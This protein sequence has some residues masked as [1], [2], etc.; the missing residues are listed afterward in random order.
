MKARAVIAMLFLSCLFLILAACGGDSS[1]TSTPA[2]TPTPAGSP[3]TAP[4]GSET[5]TPTPQGLEHFRIQQWRVI[6]DNGTPTLSTSATASDNYSLTLIGPKGNRRDSG[7]I[8]EGTSEIKL[9]LADAWKAPDPGQYTLL[10]KDALDEQIA[11]QVFDF[12]G[13]NLAVSGVSCTWEINVTGTEY[14]LTN[15][16]FIAANSGDVPAY[17]DRA[18]V[19]V[20]GR[21]G[22]VP[23]N[24]VILPGATQ[25]MSDITRKPYTRYV[26][27]VAV[28]GDRALEVRLLD[29]KR[30]ILWTSKDVD[31]GTAQAIEFEVLDW[32]MVDDDGTA[33]FQAQISS[34]NAVNIA[35]VDP[36]AT[37]RDWLFSNAGTNEVV[38]HMGVEGEVPGAGGYEL[39]IKDVWGNK[40]TTQTVLI[41]GADLA[42]NLVR[43]AWDEGSGPTG[44][45]K[46]FLKNIEFSVSNGGDVPAYI[47]GTDLV[48]DGQ[49]TDDIQEV[50]TILAGEAQSIS[51]GTPA[52][53][54]FLGTAGIW[55]GQRPLTLTFTDS[56]GNVIHT[57]SET[58]NVP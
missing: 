1:P 15:L 57:H 49:S 9:K 4:P 32:T 58:I 27:G 50:R 55:G 52:S 42:T 36:A 54:G 20:R 22:T 44:A 34:D 43:L 23:L 12:E 14:T 47:R 2:S 13:I 8:A 53:W 46:Y 37:E 45:G 38:L 39:V 41:Q 30:E 18:V 6:D 35:M 28:G 16:Q 10:V 33:G 31:P 17:I 3:T 51:A 48:V 5:S 26:T 7:S 19:S 25:A 29:S 11:S 21:S 56:T 40:A 24:Q